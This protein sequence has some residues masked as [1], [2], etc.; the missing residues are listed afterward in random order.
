MMNATVLYVLAK[1]HQQDM[2]DEGVQRRV[3][4]AARKRSRGRHARSRLD[5]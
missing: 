3:L 4:S 1:Q 5:R 2:I